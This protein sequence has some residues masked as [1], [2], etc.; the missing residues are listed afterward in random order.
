M[1]Q[2][3]RTERLVGRFVQVWEDA[4]CDKLLERL[5]SILADAQNPGAAAS[6]D[7]FN[8]RTWTKAEEFRKSLAAMQEACDKIAPRRRGRKR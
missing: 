5:S 7:S 8:E 3:E 6:D 4:K 1:T 2:K